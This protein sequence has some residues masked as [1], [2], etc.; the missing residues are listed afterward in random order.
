MNQLAPHNQITLEAF[1]AAVDTYRQCGFD[2]PESIAEIADSLEQHI[3]RLDSLSEIDPTFEI[4]YKAVRSTLQNASSQRA[5]FLDTSETAIDRPHNGHTSNG[6]LAPLPPLG[7]NGHS[8][9]DLPVNPSAEPNTQP[10]IYRYTLPQ[11]ATT[12]ET[13][14]FQQQVEA[15]RQ[16]NPDWVIIFDRPQPGESDAI[17]M[18]HKDHDYPTT[19]AAYIANRTINDVVAP[20][21]NRIFGQ[22]P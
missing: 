15:I 8:K 10:T 11:S 9:T 22:R 17:V 13:A 21:L 19:H 3:A 16:A 7:T 12:Q 14:A 6:N 18:I 1:Q 4:A 20:T 2:L 5:K